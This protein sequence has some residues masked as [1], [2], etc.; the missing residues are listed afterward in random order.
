MYESEHRRLGRLRMVEIQSES[1]WTQESRS[2]AYRL[3]VPLDVDG[4]VTLEHHRVRIRGRW[5]PGR[6][7]LMPPASEVRI[8]VTRPHRALWLHLPAKAT[9]DL[10]AGAEGDNDLSGL[11]DALWSSTRVRDLALSTWRSAGPRPLRRV[12]PLR[13]FVQL[14]RALLGVDA[15]WRGRLPPTRLSQGARSR[16]VDYVEE[17]L[18]RPLRLQELAGLVGLSPFHFA[19]G[20]R[21]DMGQTPHHYVMERRVRRGLA[22]LR[23][24]AAPLARIAPQ[25]GFSRAQHMTTAFRRVYGATPG[26]VRDRR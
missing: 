25:L 16:V 22:V 4:R 9:D 11:H 1:D 3:V 8:S 21:H 15:P 19:R 10:A 12:H 17:R 13:R 14:V 6:L 2:A 5:L 24:S 26:E 7:A 20:F 18:A 23:T